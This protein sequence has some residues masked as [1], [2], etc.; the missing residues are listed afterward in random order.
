MNLWYG[1]LK[2]GFALGQRPLIYLAYRVLSATPSLPRI[3]RIYGVDRDAR[4]WQLPRYV[5]VSK[6][7]RMFI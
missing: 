5:H 6:T 7:A 2:G 1:W 3:R 4:L